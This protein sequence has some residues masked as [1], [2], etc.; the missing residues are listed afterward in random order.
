METFLLLLLAIA[1][2]AAIVLFIHIKDKHEPEPLRL[3][4]LGVGCGV[5]SFLLALAIGKPL[6]DYTDIDRTD[7]IDQLIRAFI[8]VG[9]VE[10]VSKFL[11]LRG[12]LYR[13]FDEPL[14]GIVYAVMVG[15]GFATAENILYIIQGGGGTAITRM[16]TAVPAHGVFAVIMGFFL[17][18][19]KVFPTSS[20]L[21]HML[22]LAFATFV[23]GFYDYFLFIS[24]IPGLWIQAF[25]GLLIA[26][27]LTHFAIK[28]HQRDS[29]FNKEMEE[30]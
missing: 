26:V 25:V 20:G 18:E 15:M 10:E 8:F 2:G 16:F 17:G 11:F 14:D 3:L 7:V 4:L 19:A 28:R 21:F 23:H 27:V 9:L 13:H 29:P 22:G 24:F 1:P 30:D 6:H 5:L 12:I